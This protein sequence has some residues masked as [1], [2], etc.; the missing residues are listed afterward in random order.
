MLIV[1]A[2]LPTPFPMMMMR[3][4]VHDVRVRVRVR[5]CLSMSAQSA[6][7]GECV[8]IFSSLY[9]QQA[10]IM[11]IKKGRFREKRKK[12]QFSGFSYVQLTN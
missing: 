3:T 11:I 4:Y 5:M 6:N 10:G 7:V 8:E 2:F 12:A 1:R 9:T